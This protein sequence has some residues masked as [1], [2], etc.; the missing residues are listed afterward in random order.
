MVDQIVRPP[1][2][3]AVV[4]DAIRGAIFRGDLQPG[5]PLREVEL[6]QSLDVSRGTVREA[7][8]MLHKERL[9]E[10]KPHR[11]AFVRK[12]SPRTAA[13]IDTLRALVEPYAVRVA[14]ENR[15]YS[16]QDLEALAALARRVDELYEKG[17]MIETIKADVAFHRLICERSDHQLLVRVLDNIQS[18]MMQFMLNTRLYRSDEVSDEHSHRAIVEAIRQ[19]DPVFAEKIL[20]EHIQEAR[21]LLLGRMEEVDW[22]SINVGST[23]KGGTG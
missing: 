7:L 3:T 14:L 17:D 5:E 15:A 23:G 12:L 10:I 16:E 1:T 2:L 22:D 9:I 18:L 21:T 20:R 13:E 19:G 11:G 4:V 8:R 6:S